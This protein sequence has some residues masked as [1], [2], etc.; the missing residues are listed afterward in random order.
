MNAWIAAL[1][2]IAAPLA[3]SKQNNFK[4][5]EERREKQC[6][7]LFSFFGSVTEPAC[8]FTQKHCEM[9]RT[10]LGYRPQ[11]VCSLASC[12]P[13]LC[14]PRKSVAKATK[15]PFSV[16]SPFFGSSFRLI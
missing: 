12:L 9:R 8:F 13:F 11:R 16:P 1:A 4:E 15:Q 6:S 7:R 14:F 10:T 3:L 2:L 5:K